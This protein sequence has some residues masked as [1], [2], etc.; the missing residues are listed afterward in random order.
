MTSNKPQP[1]E[2]SHIDCDT[3]LSEIPASVAQSPEG[4]EYIQHY[5]GLACR[6]QLV[7]P[8]E[9]TVSAED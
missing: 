9:K 4:D 6:D 2:P 7:H 3:C 8:G 1:V 5:C